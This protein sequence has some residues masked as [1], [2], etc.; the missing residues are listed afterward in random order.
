M[1]KIRVKYCLDGVDFVWNRKVEYAE[2]VGPQ[3]N[4]IN[5]SVEILG[6]FVFEVKVK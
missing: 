6:G 2:D 1:F 4:L 5:S 3:L